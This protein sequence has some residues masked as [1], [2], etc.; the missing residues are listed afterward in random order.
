MIDQKNEVE[1]TTK[2]VVEPIVK[3]EKKS[4]SKKNSDKKKSEKSAD[5][6]NLSA[7]LDKIPANKAGSKSTKDKIYKDESYLSDFDGG[8][9]F[10]QSMRKKIRTFLFLF[11]DAI[12]TKKDEKIV[13]EKFKSF[14]DFY[15]T[16]YLRNDFTVESIA[17]GNTNE[18]TRAE[19]E[20]YFSIVKIYLS[21]KK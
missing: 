2:E 17:S 8:K 16:N 15:K 20:N 12:R 7:L 9:K 19:L 11:C 5:E 13:S 10:R 4:A 6:K 1:T 21:R 14:S 18:R 3:A